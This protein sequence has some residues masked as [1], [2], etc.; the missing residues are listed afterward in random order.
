MIQDGVKFNWS[1]QVA[2]ADSD[3]EIN[4]NQQ[5]DFRS[6]FGFMAK[7]NPS[8]VMM[9]DSKKA[10]TYSSTSVVPSAQTGLTSL[11][12]MVRGEP[13]RYN[14]LRVMDKL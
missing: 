10:A 8:S 14:H 6:I 4:E 9:R 12:G 3:F 1:I 13:R 5:S 2:K 11:F 7:K